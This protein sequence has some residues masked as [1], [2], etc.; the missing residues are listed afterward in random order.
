MNKKIEEILKSKPSTET[1]MNSVKIK[2]NFWKNSIKE[3]KNLLEKQKIEN[4]KLKPSL[5]LYKIEFTL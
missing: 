1:I 5:E 2:K 4:D 3:Q